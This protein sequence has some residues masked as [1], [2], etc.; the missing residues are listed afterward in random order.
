MSNDKSYEKVRAAA[1]VAANTYGF[2][3]G[4]ET[5]DDGKTYR[6]F[7]LPGRAHRR[8]HELRCEV[9]SCENLAKCQPGHGYGR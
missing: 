9:V 4:V 3:Y 5:L 6:H 2:D 8:G 1:Q 7:M